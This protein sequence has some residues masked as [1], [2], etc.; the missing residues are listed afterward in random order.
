MQEWN[1]I[2]DEYRNCT[3]RVHLRGTPWK[4]GEYGLTVCVWVYDGS[5]HFLLTRRA[6][7]KSFQGTW[8]NTGGAAQAG[9]TSRQAIAGSYLRKPASG[10]KNRSLNFLA[11]TGI[12]A[13]FMTS[14]V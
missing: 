4:P 6:K 12:N 3:G 11:P 8:E 7:G 5:G 14:T 10:Q 9:E 1:D 2:Y 13:P